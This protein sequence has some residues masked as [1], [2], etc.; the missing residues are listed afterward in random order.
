MF[1][2]TTSLKFIY[3]EPCMCN[4]I[5]KVVVVHSQ[6]MLLLMDALQ[7]AEQIKQKT[8]GGDE[9]AQI[10]AHIEEIKDLLILQSGQLN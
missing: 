9:R 4:A 10:N 3:G 2:G 7:V 6:K 1:N 8:M 5:A